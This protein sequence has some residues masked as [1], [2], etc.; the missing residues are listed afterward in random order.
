MADYEMKVADLLDY[1]PATDDEES[2][3]DDSGGQRRELTT[4]EVG[5]LLEPKPEPVSTA[6]IGPK[7]QPTLHAEGTPKATMPPAIEEA[8]HVASPSELQSEL[9]KVKAELE[10]LKEVNVH[11]SLIHISEPTRPY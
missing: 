5:K 1:E 9:E 4:A 2:G 10:A 8:S 3:N 7:Y 11:L 6:D